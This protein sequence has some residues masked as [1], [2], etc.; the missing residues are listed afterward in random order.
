M[1]ETRQKRPADK[2][3]VLGELGLKD[4]RTKVRDRGNVGEEVGY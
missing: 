2:T 1:T 3:H 4:G